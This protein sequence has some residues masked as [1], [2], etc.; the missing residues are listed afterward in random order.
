MRI[1][2]HSKNTLLAFFV[3]VAFFGIQSDALAQ[4]VAFNNTWSGTPANANAT[5]NNANLNTTV[6]SRGTGISGSSSTARFSASGFATGTSPVFTN[7]DY[8]TFTITASSGYS[9][10]LNNASITLG[11][12][13]SGTGPQTYGVYT[14]IGGFTSTASQVGANL[15]NTT[16]QARTFPATGYDGLSTIEIRIYGWNASA[17]AGTGGPATI[18]VSG[19]VVANN[20]APTAT[21]VQ[22]SGTTQIGQTLTGSYTFNDTD[23][24]LQGTSTYRW[25][26]ADN[27]S[28]LNVT[29]IGGATSTTYT[30]V[31][32]DA[33]KFI[34]FGVTPVAA[35]GTPTGTETF[36]AYAGPVTTS[37]NA[38]STITY[39]LGFTPTSNVNYL[40]Y[41]GSNVT[42]TSLEVAK[43]NLNDVVGSPDDALSTTLTALSFSVSGFEQFEKIALYDDTNTEIQE[44]ASATTANFSGLT[45][46][47]ASGSS[48]SFSVRAT[49][50]PV[51]TDNVQPQLT[52]TS[53]TA[54]ANGS[55]F[56]A[57][58]GGGA[59]SSV[60]GDHNKIEVTATAL[61]FV[62]DATNTNVNFNMSPAITVKAVDTNLNT[63]IDFTGN[64]TIT[65]TGTLAATQNANA[66]SGVATFASIN[67]TAQQNGAQLTAVSTGLSNATSALFNLTVPEAGE[68]LLEENFNFS[69]VL[70]SNGWTQI[71]SVNTNPITTTTGLS[72]NEYG[73]TNVGNAAALTTGQDVYKTFA[74]QNPGAG[75]ITAYYAT[76][77]SV[78]T[79][80]TGGDYFITLGESSTFAGG[81]TFRARLF[82]K[83]GSSATKV[84][85]GIAT[86]STVTYDTTEYDTNTAILLAVKYVFSTTAST[87]YL[88]VNPSAYSEPLVASATSA[89]A[90]TVAIGLDAIALR[91]GGASSAPAVHVDGIRV[92]TN[93][94]TALGNPQYVVTA[95][96]NAGNYNSVTVYGGT[97]SP[98]GAVTVNNA[99]TVQAG[100]D[101]AIP[102][103]TN[104]IQK[105]AVNNNSGKITVNRNALM[106]R[107]D[108]VYWSSPVSGQNILDFSPLTITN[109]FYEINE[110]SNTFVALTT[111][112]FVNA[113]GYAIRA[114]NTFNS[115][116]NAAPQTFNGVF[117]GVPNN[118]DISIP[119]TYSG[120]TKG[121]NLI[122]NPYPSTINATELLSANPIVSTLYFWAHVN[123]NAASGA[124][125][126]TFNGVGQA[127]ATGGEVPNGTIQTGQGFLAKVSASGSVNFTNALRVN[128][129]AGQFFRNAVAE[130]SRFWLNLSENDSPKNQILVGYVTDATNELDN[131]FDAQLI[132]T[133]GSK[134]YN[135]IDNSEYVIQGRALPF[136]NTDE[137]ALGFKTETAGNFTISMDHFDGLFAEN[138]DIFVKDITTGTIHNI[139]ETPYNFASAAGTF[140]NR[141]AVVYQNATLGIE[142]PGL[143]ADSIVIFKQNNKLNINSGTVVMQ[144]VKIFDISGRLI[145]DN[146]N[147]NASTV[148]V[149]INVAQQVLVVQI[150]SNDNKTVTKKV[151]F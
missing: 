63:D 62:Q 95:N 38:L 101:F 123:Q 37:T 27:N 118:G 35:T 29:P 147:I 131:N 60:M 116:P 128:N 68:L 81:A 55:F 57:V 70:T 112:N 8:F 78:S 94:G 86:G 41:L 132:E 23:G 106:K 93:W 111:S 69:G 149:S 59:S 5:T 7:N 52:I 25:L 12:S 85:F 119:V 83:Q 104:L 21:A 124:N 34:R 97:L 130:K 77:A 151:V 114:P 16:G 24:D 46:V 76:V 28:G 1:L 99:I 58:N 100:A 150:T 84:L 26:R 87:A 51:V 65:S 49:F 109:R 48:K 141:F 82:A 54:D 4:I 125:Y 121:F 90:S 71:A 64:V 44:V 91:Q 105:G 138:Q 10:N 129:T 43:F 110:V 137:V 146:N 20:S 42:G 72:Y 74:S 36:S 144:N 39:D 96:I 120:A 126:A 14:S 33:N 67:H 9:I 40:A 136:V 13:A 75:T 140:N 31:A 15:T 19:A 102:N 6:L 17:A 61:Q 2:L 3:S 139:K 30:L 142:N 89:V 107:L 32:G 50:K 79:P 135:L 66:V 115:N 56:A 45:I 53:A 11:L 117:N 143:N 108:Y 92:A 113:K 80:T 127:A 133:S 22:I 134:L 88:Y 145:Y 98:I 122:G 73:S 103:N 47:A 18:S 148:A